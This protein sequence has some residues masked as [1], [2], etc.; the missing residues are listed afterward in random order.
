MDTEQMTE[1][2]EL[3]EDRFLFSLGEQRL[4]ATLHR[5]EGTAAA[6]VIL[7]HGWAGYRGGPHQMFIKLGRQAAEAGF[8]CLRF[9]FRGRGD[10]EGNPQAASLSTMIA[11]TRRAAEI[12]AERCGPLPLALV[13]DCSGSEVAIGAGAL[14][15]AV[16]RLVLWS[17]PPV[18]ADREE[19][20]QAKRASV[21]RTYLRKALRPET[22]R[23]L[24]QGRLRLDR[25]R[26]TLRTGGLGAG[27]LGSAS[28]QEIDW[29]GRFV[30]FPGRVL[31]LYGSNDPTTPACLQH[32][33]ELTDRAGRPFETHLVQ[34]ANHAF[35]SLAWEQEVINT[36]LQWL[37]EWRDHP[38]A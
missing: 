19:M 6:G 36:T 8:C 1:T 9:D 28:D 30:G 22:W 26:Q 4:V 37:E 23:R 38:G 11:D 24:L 18:A 35:Y 25:V 12:V 5:P 17:A 2:Q 14:I 21:L 15:P 7:L 29:L 3:I 13:G 16:Q 34:G 27:E 10:S 32:Y 31:F 20:R 33:Q